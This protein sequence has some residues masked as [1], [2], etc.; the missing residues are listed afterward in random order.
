M[1]WANFALIIKEGVVPA[2]FTR[3]KL[4]VRGVYC[5][6][7]AARSKKLITMVQGLLVFVA[8]EQD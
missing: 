3:L 4:A 7:Q 5:R 6:S 2:N 1:E 8:F